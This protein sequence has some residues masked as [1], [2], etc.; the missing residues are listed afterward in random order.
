MNLVEKLIKLAEELEKE[1]FVDEADELTDAIESS[2]P[3]QTPLSNDA[4]EVV[5][6]NPQ[7]QSIAIPKMQD[8]MV[9]PDN[10]TTPENEAVEDTIAL[11]IMAEMSKRGLTLEEIAKDDRLFVDLAAVIFPY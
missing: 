1:G 4:P 5:V 3:Q 6:D 10:V 9:K 2:I 7:S 8:N 11:A